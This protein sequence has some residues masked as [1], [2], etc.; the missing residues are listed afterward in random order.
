MRRLL[1]LLVAVVI[2]RPFP[3]AGLENPP[4]LHARAWLLIEYATGDVLVEHNADR[5]LPPASLTKLMTAYLVFEQLRAGNV[6]LDD[7]VA[8][9]PFAARTR[10][11][12]VPLKP[13]AEV[14]IEDLIK[15]MVLRSANNAAVALAEHI[16]G[17]EPLFVAAMNAR[18]RAWGLRGTSF[19]NSTG[20]DQPGHLS[21]ARDMSRIAAALIRDFPDYYRWFSLRDFAFNDNL[22]RN[23]NG[24]LWRN[25]AV[26]GMKTGYTRH[27]GW[28]LI[29]TASQEHMRLI[30]AVLGAPSAAARVNSSQRLLDYGFRNFETRLVYAANRPAVE[31]RVWM[32]D[33]A[34]VPLGTLEN[35]YLTLPRG[36][37]SRLQTRLRLEDM[38]YA[39]VR[40]GQR[41]A[42]LALELDDKVL[43][44]YP[45]IA[46]KEVR[47]GGMVQRAIDNLQLWLR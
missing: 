19:A 40:Y 30:A 1:L 29:S 46:L 32:G 42:V 33:S 11:S 15:S 16:A 2:L 5:P 26:D 37:H 38:P 43:G 8:V 41:L 47:A 7:A 3:A 14:A 20:L 17:S 28:C 9:S 39:P 45:L 24:L 22:I 36:M 4:A 34:L 21:T 23:S 18:A 10:G 12:R 13:G 44:E 27:A 6:G 35:L 25:E 31:I